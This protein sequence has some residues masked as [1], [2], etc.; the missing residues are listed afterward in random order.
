MNWNTPVYEHF[1]KSSVYS[2]LGKASNMYS[3]Q[4]PMLTRMF[5]RNEFTQKA[6]LKH[7]YFS[8][9][10]CLTKNCTKHYFFIEVKHT[11]NSC[12]NASSVPRLF[13]T[14]MYIIMYVTNSL[15]TKEDINGNWGTFEEKLVSY[16][17]Q[18]KN[19]RS[20]VSNLE[21]RKT[22]VL[23]SLWTWMLLN[24]FKMKN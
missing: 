8:T 15:G 12:I 17:I 2:R 13:I 22:Y 11:S 20:L 10:T 6:L 19:V 4:P 5:S 9:L 7:N 3:L 23:H 21:F 18:K 1:H 14:Y 16:L 24:V